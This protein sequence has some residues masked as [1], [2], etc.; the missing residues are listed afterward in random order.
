MKQ[1]LVLIGNG[2]AGMRV[3]EE[4]L[5]VA[6]DQYDITVFG[7]EPHGNYNRILLSQVLAGE[8]PFADTMLND[9]AWYAQRGIALHRGRKVVAL[10]RARRQVIAA[11]GTIASYDRL[12][13]A[14]GAR[15]VLLP[16]P[17]AHLR[18]VLGF[19]NM[20]DVQAM[21][22][23]ARAGKRAVVIGGGLLGLEAAWGLHRRGMQVTV[24]HL[25]DRL[26]E[27]QLDAPAAALL[28]RSIEERGLKV[29]LGHEAGALLGK[30]R[31]SGV[32]LRG[33]DTL[34]ADLV[35]M[36]V[37]IQ[38]NTELAAQSGIHCE[39]G[40]VVNDAMQSYDPRVYA[41]GECV[42]HGGHTYGLV[43]PL[44]RQAKVC[45]NH[46]AG[47]G[48]ARFQ[49][50]VLATK[51]KITGI[52]LYSAGNVTGG[53]GFDEL[54]MQDPQRGVYKKLVVRG[55]R[56]E[57]ALLYGDTEN[58]SWYF[59]L[60]RD[61]T[62]VSGLRDHLLFGRGHGG[63]TG[64][65]ATAIAAMPDDTEVCG[66]NGIT[67]GMIVQAVT[68]KGL[69]TLDE[70]RTHTKAAAS[71]GSCAGKVEQILAFTLGGSYNPAPKEK[72]LCPCTDFTHA[73]VRQA[74]R[75]NHLVS[76][77]ETMKFLE[78]KT[79]D[80]CPRCRPALNFY[81][82]ATWPGEAQ[83]DP[84][85]RVHNERVHANIQQDGTYAVVPRCWGGLTNAREL[86]AIADVAER[87]NVPVKVT[88]G[89]RLAIPFVKKEDL[90]AVWTELGKAG[91]V[92]GY[93]YGK[94]VRSVKSCV[95]KNLCRFGTQ[96]SLGLGIRL[97]QEF[98]GAWTPHKFKMGV[99]GC[100]RN[101]AE[102]T[103]KDL[104]LVGVD[105]GWEV[106][107]GGTCGVRVR[108]TDLLCKVTNDDAAREHA[109]AFL[110]LYREEGFYMERSGAWI[111]RVGLP[112]VK[113]RV[114]EEA[115]HRRALATRFF[116]AQK[117]A[118]VDPWKERAGNSAYDYEYQALEAA[119]A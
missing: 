34:P 47:A 114:V 82:I 19:R 21:L 22:E 27:R 61:G 43:A 98:W 31:V 99:S 3:I 95:G 111:E 50:A 26:M 81:L 13:L 63:D 65:G 83:D 113:Q 39:R 78:W 103:I 53:S 70:V 74:I 29:V 94:A 117:H 91:L 62:D 17:G 90:P 87:M 10:N 37:G 107:V 54:V 73:E 115:Q 110:Q 33:G 93:A 69:F 119:S 59:D 71:C 44:F 85:S 11:D 35:V 18:G 15:P 16:L 9:E 52:D 88:G 64:H 14:T 80:G 38:P 7:E 5:A 112:Y 48:F 45:A 20:A 1:R 56:L 30:G 49:D 2:M 55:N 57:G 60:M 25:M 109:A 86:R 6:P 116:S 8:K 100:P 77:P 104:G 79:P 28:R 97:E 118:Q 40:I 75:G 12:V 89:Q 46:L 4:L 76:I 66:C 106:H 72:P 102:A 68:S 92:S 105:S 23:V 32:Q 96:D 84:Q 101:C 24:L 58:E 51:L 41:V 36:A 42:Q 108:A 67:K